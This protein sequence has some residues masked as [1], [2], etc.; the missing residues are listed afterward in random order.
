MF[1]E[2]VFRAA[3]ERRPQFLEE[4]RQARLL[5]EAK[6]T[7]KAKTTSQNVLHRFKVNLTFVLPVFTPFITRLC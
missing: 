1:Y 4:A 7:P 5:N 6:L 2:S 3:L